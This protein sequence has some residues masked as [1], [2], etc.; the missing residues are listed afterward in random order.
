MYINIYTLLFEIKYT[1][2]MGHVAS[3]YERQDVFL[4]KK[5][6]SKGPEQNLQTKVLSSEVPTAFCSRFVGQVSGLSFVC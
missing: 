6:F 5:S 2:L 4:R 3:A 1:I